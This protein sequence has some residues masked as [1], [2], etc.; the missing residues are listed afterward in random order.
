MRSLVA[1]AVSLAVCFA[2]AGL[3][4]ALTRPSLDDWYPALDKPAW[5][6]PDG[7]FGPVWTTL[8]ALMAI[9]AW[10]VWRRRQAEPKA[11]R[12]A[13]GWFATQ[14][15]LN[16]GWSLLF[17]GLR[18]PG[19][20]LLEILLL[21]GAILATAQAARRVDA[22]AAALLIPYMVWVSFA[23]ALNFAIWSLN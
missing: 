4:A 11:A 18:A 12:V 8:F 23:A 1:L 2:A 13:L 22:P 6:P 10:R 15:A 21:W 17:F 19:W 9:A 3:G 14:L 7:V 5:T 20:A 16:V